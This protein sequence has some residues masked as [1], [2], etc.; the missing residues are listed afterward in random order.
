MEYLFVKKVLGGVLLKGTP[1]STFVVQ[2][3]GKKN[4]EESIA[5]I[6]ESCILWRIGGGT[7]APFR[8][9]QHSTPHVASS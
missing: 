2:S 4:F 9:L 8:P 1:L 6:T 7:M 3:E 5:R